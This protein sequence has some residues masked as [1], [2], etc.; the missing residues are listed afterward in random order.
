M[1]DVAPGGT[2][3][4]FELAALMP[5]GHALLSSTCPSAMSCRFW[6]G[7]A[8][9]LLRAGLCMPLCRLAKVK[10]LRRT[11]AFLPSMNPMNLRIASKKQD[12]PLI[13]FGSAKTR[14][15]VGLQFVG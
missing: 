10:C 7:F 5:Y 13:G 12:S 6:H 8:C 2:S 3:K 14:Y 1:L 15:R 4:S 9:R 11:D